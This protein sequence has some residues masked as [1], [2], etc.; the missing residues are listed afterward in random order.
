MKVILIYVKIGLKFSSRIQYISTWVTYL[1]ASGSSSLSEYLLS[2]NYMLGIVLD[3]GN[4]A[5]NN[6][7][8]ASAFMRLMISGS[9]ALPRE[10][11]LGGWG[12]RGGPLE[13]YEW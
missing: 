10:A 1:V 6:T 8:N 2:A 12:G 4:K 7:S 9:I 11:A 13:P 5:V 3:T